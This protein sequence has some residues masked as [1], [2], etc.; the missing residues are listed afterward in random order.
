MEDVLRGTDEEDFWQLAE[1]DFIT[2]V[3][4]KSGLCRGN[5]V[6]A[7]WSLKYD[8]LSY[9][10]K[11]NS[12]ALYRGHHQDNKLG[13]P[14]GSGVILRY[15]QQMEALLFQKENLSFQKVCITGAAEGQQG[16]PLTPFALGG[17]QGKYPRV[18]CRD[19]TGFAAGE[20]VAKSRLPH[21][22]YSDPVNLSHLIQK[23]R[24]S[25]VHQLLP[26]FPNSHTLKT[27]S[28]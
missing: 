5:L 27:R 25:Q 15:V 9:R 14:C 1:R 2:V 22:E 19:I 13:S 10:G 6:A 11:E 8:L 24:I 21:T 16:L 23:A 26:I 3:V 20:V 4:L 18:C 28:V 17:R 7:F 12:A